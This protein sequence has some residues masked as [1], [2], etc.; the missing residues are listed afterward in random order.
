MCSIGKETFGFAT[1]G[2]SWITGDFAD[3][4]QTVNGFTYVASYSRSP[5]KAKAFAEKHGARK[6]YTDLEQ[7]LSDPDIDAVYIASPNSLHEEQSVLAMEH[8]KN[9]ICEKPAASNVRELDRVLDCA[10]KNGVLYMEAYKTSSTPGFA[11]IADNLEKLGTLRSAFFG[12]SKYSSRYDAHKRHED[13]NTFKAEFSNG[14]LMDLGVY[15][16]Y[17]M[18]MLFGMPS[19]I[20][21]VSSIVEGGVDGSGSSLFA[22][23]GFNVALSYS[24]TSNSFI[25]SE[26]QG[27]DATMIINRINIPDAI[28]IRYRD[29]RSEQIP[30]TQKKEDMYYEIEHYVDCLRKGLTESPLNTHAL[31]RNVLSVCDAIRK[32][33]GPE[34]PADR[35]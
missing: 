11:A 19:E 33:A 16:I 20:K 22:Y 26:I 30:V 24:K 10:A 32:Q 21:G 2:T 12:F 6:Q 9:V 15:C 31:S 8:G 23:G 29:G 35:I 5:E 1:I 7:M 14:A 34:F 13:V 4:G 3:I 25:P 27:E 28:E 17:P 18:I